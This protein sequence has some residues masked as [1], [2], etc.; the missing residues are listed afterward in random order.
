MKSIDG[1]NIESQT[2]RTRFSQWNVLFQCKPP[3]STRN[4]GQHLFQ[5][6]KTCLL[7]SKWKVRMIYRSIPQSLL[8][9]KIYISTTIAEVNADNVVFFPKK[10]E[11]PAVKIDVFLTQAEKDTIKVLANIP[12]P[13]VPKFEA[14]DEIKNALLKLE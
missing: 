10:T 8:F 7:G 12:A 3:C 6:Y 13:K 4:K 11:L 5:T 1:S 2:I 9:S 14:G